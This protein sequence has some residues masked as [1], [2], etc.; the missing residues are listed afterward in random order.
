[1]Y[2]AR[3]AEAE[4]REKAEQRAVAVE[5]KNAVLVG[6]NAAMAE[7]LGRANDLLVER[8]CGAV[9]VKAPATGAAAGTPEPMRGVDGWREARPLAHE[10]AVNP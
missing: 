8:G 4:A 7:A 2:T 1:M 3:I 5:G 10:R 9:I 6:Q